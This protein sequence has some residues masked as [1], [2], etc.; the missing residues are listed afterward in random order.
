MAK[1]KAYPEYKTISNSWLDSIPKGWELLPL[2]Y[3]CT[4]F[5]KDGPHE[6]PVF[7]EE[8]VPFLSVDGIQNN[9]LVFDGCRY[10]SPSDHY[11][12]SQKCKPVKGDV[13]LGKA[14]SIGK[15]ALVDTSI[16]FNV[17]SPLAVITPIRSCL[18]KFIYYSFQTT[19]LQAQCEVYSNSNTQKNLGMNTIDNL[20][21]AMPSD[22]E[23][24]TISNFLD[25]E[26]AKIDNLIEK[27]QKLIELLKEKRQAVISAV[28]SIRNN[29][30]KTKL[31]N[32][33]SIQTGYPFSSAK[34]KL[35]PDNNI[36]LLR[37][38][39]V[40]V[41]NIK[42]DDVVYWDVSA[43]DNLNEYLLVA[44][45]IVFGMDRPWISSGARVSEIKEQDLPCLLLQR[46]ARIR[47]NINSYQPFIKLCL[48]S[49]EFREYAEIDLTGVSVPHISPEQISNF[50]VRD[51]PFDDQVVLTKKVLKQIEKIQI[52]QEMVEQTIR[53]LQE[54][55]TA[56]ISAAVTGKI[57]VRDWVA[58]DTQESEE[59][60][61]VSA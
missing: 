59:P 17:W 35:S 6:T 8:G 48:S 41:D 29:E 47:S 14:A 9:K 52:T 5:V 38:V 25:H 11:R 53:I 7:L 42:W 32:L 39:N 34:F 20:D 23:A 10:I 56:L 19:M 61:E 54:R 50:Y 46:V 3:L 26:T 40:G 21:F 51:I 55:R 49:N 16:E 44:D 24:S 2:K 58:P 18:S 13:L 28:V 1:Y 57:D 22:K 36:P 60:Q 4:S 33:V 37:G 43:L 31:K 27:Q 12:F 30:G 45:D 15:V